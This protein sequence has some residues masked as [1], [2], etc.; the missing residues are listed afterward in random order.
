M[1]LGFGGLSITLGIVH[2]A[3]RRYIYRDAH[4]LDTVFDAGGNVTIGLTAVTVTSQLLWPADF[5]Q[6]AT[7]MSK[8]KKNFKVKQLKR[9]VVWG[10]I[11]PK[12]HKWCLS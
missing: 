3:V 8:V 4:S 10:A 6:S 5:L 12:M 2:F 1:F 11:Y 9:I 7:I